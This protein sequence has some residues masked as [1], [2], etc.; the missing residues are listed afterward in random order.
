[1]DG[2]SLCKSLTW[3]APAH[4]CVS[5]IVAFLPFEK[6]M[7]LSR[8][9]LC[10][11]I[12]SRKQWER[13]MV[14]QKSASK[15]TARATS[16]VSSLRVR[17]RTWMTQLAFSMSYLQWSMLSFVEWSPRCAHVAHAPKFIFVSL[18]SLYLFIVEDKV[19]NCALLCQCFELCLWHWVNHFNN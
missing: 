4:N 5:L 8:S 6:K 17:S 11:L 12:Q 18:V 7:F 10:I 15:M 2:F 13:V 19:A 1:M 9:R 16:P 3:F 14:S